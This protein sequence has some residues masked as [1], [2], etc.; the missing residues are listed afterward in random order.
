MHTVH[1][2]CF[3]IPYY[4]SY[5]TQYPGKFLLSYLPRKSTRHEFVTVTPEGIRYRSRTFPALASVVRW[6]KEHFRDPIP[7]QSLCWVVTMEVYCISFTATVCR[8]LL[9]V[10]FVMPLSRM[11]DRNNYDR[12]WLCCFM[13]IDRGVIDE[14]TVCGFIS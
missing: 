9:S 13:R 12:L 5:S 14:Y 1:I 3:R 8:M 7:G 2:C 11:T 10:L 6:F 4:L